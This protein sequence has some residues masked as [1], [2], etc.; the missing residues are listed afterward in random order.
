MDAQQPLHPLH[1]RDAH[2]QQPLLIRDAHLQPLHPLPTKDAHQPLLNLL[3]HL[4]SMLLPNSLPMHQ[5]SEDT[6][7]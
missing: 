3:P 1:I 2:L 4:L 7:S 5:L 6:L